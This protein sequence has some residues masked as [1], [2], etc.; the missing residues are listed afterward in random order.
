MLACCS[1]M[2]GCGLM[3]AAQAQK[4]V[5]PADIANLKRVSG[6]QI[7]PDGIWSSTR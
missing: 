4:I 1:A 5:D 6:P 7:S 2:F 3:L